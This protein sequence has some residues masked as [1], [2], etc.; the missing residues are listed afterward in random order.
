MR[1]ERDLVAVAGLPDVEEVGVAGGSD[2]ELL[3]GGGAAEGGADIFLAV[4]ELVEGDLE[5]RAGL[6]LGDV[7]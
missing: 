6:E 3:L 5:R 1:P 7:L 2:R 4:G